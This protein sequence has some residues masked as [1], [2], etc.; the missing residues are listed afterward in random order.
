MT[1]PET[2]TTRFDRQVAEE[3]QQLALTQLLKNPEL[4]GVIVVFDYNNGLNVTDTITGVWQ[5]RRQNEKTPSEL[6]G[7][8]SQ[9]TKMLEG[10]VSNVDTMINT[11]RDNLQVLLQETH[12]RMTHD[13]GNTRSKPAKDT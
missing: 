7:G 4:R 10:M 1:T 6:F 13:T 11:A 5:T 8:I 9:A 2:P 3:F 12:N